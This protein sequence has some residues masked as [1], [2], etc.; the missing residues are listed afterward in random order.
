MHTVSNHLKS[1]CW[2]SS[3]SVPG[4]LSLIPAGV[5]QT[6]CRN[7]RAPC[8]HKKKYVTVE[9][10]SHF[11]TQTSASKMVPSLKSLCLD[12]SK[13]VVSVHPSR[14]LAV[15]RQRANTNSIY[16][17]ATTHEGQNWKQ[18]SI[19][20][21]LSRIDASVVKQTGTKAWHRPW[22]CLQQLHSKISWNSI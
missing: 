4:V 12:C 20:N 15:P 8:C 11:T 17:K 9:K 3:R 13:L 16:E 18:L 6:Y 19:L 22:Q 1:C 5:S 14:A 21:S 2:D 7:S 10:L